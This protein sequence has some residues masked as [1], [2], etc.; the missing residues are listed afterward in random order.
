MPF[1]VMNMKHFQFFINYVLQ[2]TLNQYTFVYQDDILI[3]SN[4]LTEPL[5]CEAHSSMPP[6]FSS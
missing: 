1:G 5:V 6:R 4:P 3:F 2:E